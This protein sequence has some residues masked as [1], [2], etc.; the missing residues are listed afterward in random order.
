MNLLVAGIVAL[1]AA[2]GLFFVLLPR[3]GRVHR[4]VDT[5]LEPYVAVAI[6][7]LLALAFTLLLS[8]AMTAIG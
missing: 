1:V 2:L 8:G 5:E 3:G 7:A 6:T 4:F